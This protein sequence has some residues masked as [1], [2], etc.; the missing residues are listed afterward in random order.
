MASLTIYDLANQLATLL[1]KVVPSWTVERAETES[2]AAECAGLKRLSDVQFEAWVS[3]INGNEKVVL[4]CL[5]ERFPTQDEVRLMQRIVAVFRSDL[6]VVGEVM[7]AQDLWEGVA[8]TQFLRAAARLS[9]FSTTPLLRWTST[10]AA[11]AR[12]TYEG[13]SFTGSVI[14]VKH[15][16]TF[17]Q[18]V[19][20]RLHL[21]EQPLGFD[22]ALLREK[23]LKPFL[24]EGLF[25]LVTVGHS[26][27]ARGFADVSDPRDEV[28]EVLAP[29]EELEGL[30]GL[31]RAGTSILSVSPSGDIYFALSSGVTFVN[32]QGHWRYQSWKG[33][34]D[35]LEHR[36]GADV[37]QRALRLVAG[38][39]YERRGSLYVFLNEGVDPSQVVPD[40]ADTNRHARTLRATV[41]GG[42]LND[43]KSVRVL[44]SAS[45]VDGAVVFDHRGRISD[46]ASMISEPSM[47]ALTAAG[48]N[49]LKRFP[50]AR[51]TAA[52][53][54][55]IYG[56]AIKVSEDGPVDVYEGGKHVFHS[57]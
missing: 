14:L 11:A 33:L 30:Y 24:Q 17:R 9:P 56:L 18:R 51:S 41:A 39:S 5:A 35:V 48:Q 45:G 29:V 36:L 4:G 13:A 19:G 10:F 52:W 44:R 47:D 7:V 22:Q 16:P 1:G 57:G 38:A 12:Q 55:S 25:A 27:V 28:P 8:Q 31:L 54:A 43:P 15:L 3:P 2:F 46:V 49:H 21:F 53:N 26:G 20:G 50:G 34:T 6:R 37:G 40:H 23:W 32:S 42:S